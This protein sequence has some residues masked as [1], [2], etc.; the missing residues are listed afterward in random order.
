MLEDAQYSHGVATL[1]TGYIRP[2]F[3]ASH[4]LVENRRAAF[5]DTGTRHAVPRLLAA[6][7]RRGL[8]PAAVDYVFVTHAHLDH[9]GGA[10]ALL[11][12]LPNA[13]LVAHPR[14]APHLVNPDKLIAGAE[15]V[16]GKSEMQRLYGEILPVAE[17]RVIQAG[18]G[19]T[20]ELGGRPLTCLDTPG[21]ARHHYCL[22]DE[23]SAG[24]FSGDSFGLSYRAFDNA[25]SAPIA[26]PAT[27]P[28]QFDPPALHASMDRL[29]GYRPRKIW[30]THYGPVGDLERLAEQQH[31]L[32][33]A[34]VALTRR[35][36]AEHEQPH[37][38]LKDALRAL[39]LQALERHGCLLA[40]DQAAAL[41]EPDLELNTQGLLIW[42]ARQN[43]AKR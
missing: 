38:Y 2:G 27:T 4:L 35:A 24:L 1:D 26:F 39:L 12:E 18:D 7:E 37:D 11:R 33:E 17:D 21:H 43:R 3:D 36:A 40:E 16:Y 5:V 15:A 31:E 34:F 22:W 29:L 25:A 20:L 10:G 6:L 9:A 32:I 13:R 41:L 8:E 19:L 14:A 30:L 23:A 28:V 42:W